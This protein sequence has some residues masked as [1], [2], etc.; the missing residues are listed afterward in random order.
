MITREQEK[1]C[2]LINPGSL[3]KV[4]K[5]RA[6]EKPSA[7][8]SGSFKAQKSGSESSDNLL[9]RSNLINSCSAYKSAR[10]ECASAGDISECVKIKIGNTAAYMA[11]TVYCD[12]EGNPNLWLLHL[13]N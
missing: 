13:K 2:V 4:E 11:R 3:N 7:E 5:Q 12:N 10:Y 1:T 8:R 9:T 6:T